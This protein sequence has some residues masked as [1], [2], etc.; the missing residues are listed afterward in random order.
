MRY[1]YEPVCL[2]EFD[3]PPAEMMF[4]QYLPIVMPPRPGWVDTKFRIPANLK[5][6][7]RLV[8]EV[9]PEIWERQPAYVY[10]TA[11]HLHGTAE[12][13]NRPGWHSDGFGTD[14]INFI[15]SDSRPTE[16]CIQPFTLSDDHAE[17]MRQMEEQA[18]PENIRTYGERKL[19]RL[20]AGVVHRVAPG[21]PA[22][23]RTFVKISLSKHR[24][25]LAG[26][27]HN[28]LFDYDWPMFPRDGQRNH[29]THGALSRQEWQS[30]YECRPAPGE[31]RRA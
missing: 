23:F 21:G 14:D 22:G 16:F 30:L 2:G 27:A 1:G 13:I 5:F 28:Y 11:R 31:R 15:W 24:Y 18:R 4:V 25:D 29:P 8:Y 7:D 6:V 9:L 26:N 12:Q 17:S 19:L 20:D 3:L 10:L